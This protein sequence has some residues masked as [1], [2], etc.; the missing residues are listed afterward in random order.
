M[1]ETQRYENHEPTT[2]VDDAHTIDSLAS[3]PEADDPSTALLKAIAGV[4]EADS[5]KQLCGQAIEL[6]SHLQK[7]QKLLDRRESELNAKLAMIENDIRLRR[8]RFDQ[9]DDS[10]QPAIK[11]RDRQIRSGK[12][13]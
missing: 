1:A 9:V 7:K 8:I 12:F 2:R 6:A 4:N 5:A 11:N 3:L 10:E 13:I